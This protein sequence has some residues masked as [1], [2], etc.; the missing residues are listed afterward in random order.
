M[1]SFIHNVS[2]IIIHIQRVQAMIIAH[3]LTHVVVTFVK[4]GIMFIMTW[5]LLFYTY[6]I[7]IYHIICFYI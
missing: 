5:Y 2:G 3:T 4:M 6:Q 7:I 1:N